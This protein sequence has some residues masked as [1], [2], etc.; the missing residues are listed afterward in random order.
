LDAKKGGVPDW[1]TPFFSLVTIKKTTFVS[2]YLLFTDLQFTID[3]L[4]YDLAIHPGKI[5]NQSH[6]K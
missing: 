3:V 4:F 6:R 1:H 5:V 2:R